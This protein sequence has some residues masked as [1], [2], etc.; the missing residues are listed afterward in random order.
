V[1]AINLGTPDSPDTGDVRR[2]LREF[3]SD[4]RVIDISALGRWALLNLII[5]PFRPRTSAEAYRQIWTEEGSP[6]LVHGR[7]FERALQEQLGDSFRV[8]LVMR[9]GRPSIGAGLDSLRAQGCSR[10]VVF[11][12]YP[13]E[14]SSS[15]GSSLEAAYAA[16]GERWD[17]PS[18]VA[19]PAFHDDEAF[20]DAQAAILRE[21]FEG[22][23]VEHLLFSYHGLPERQVAKSDPSGSWCLASTDCCASLRAENRGC[24]RAQCFEQSRRL[25]EL[26]NLD[27]P[28]E[29]A[30]QSRLGRT[31]WIKPHADER[32]REL[33][34]AGVKRLGLISGSFVADCLETLEELGIR[35]REDFLKHGGEEL[36]LAPSL[37]SDAR[38]VSAAAGLVRRAGGAFG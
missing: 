37:N 25:V 18:L 2:Y 16:A 34:G 13:Q 38:W 1:L 22:S 6:L 31:P 36:L 5:L 28:W 20:L 17:V 30:F 4:P 3:L 26:L 14:A 32:V 33:A 23:G 11:P 21:A 10:V 15:S 29:V 7:A 9:Y 19:V 12:L 27:L 24:Y 35:A 8:E